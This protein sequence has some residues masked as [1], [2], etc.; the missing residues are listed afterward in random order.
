MNFKALIGIY[1]PLNY[2][3]TTWFA[4][5]DD[6]NSFG[7]YFSRTKNGL[8]FGEPSLIIFDTSKY[9]QS[10]SCF[11]HIWRYSIY[12]L[13]VSTVGIFFEQLKKN[14]FFE[15]V[16][17]VYASN[18]EYRLH[19]FLSDASFASRSFLSDASSSS[20]SIPGKRSSIVSN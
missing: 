11:I 9:A 4:Q 18:Y 5:M 14:T 1:W 13:L 15:M 19:S 12:L 8:G 16:L 7:W 6:S 10:T 17:I 3:R 20:S 2:R